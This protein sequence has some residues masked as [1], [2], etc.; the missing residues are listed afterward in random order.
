[1][2]NQLYDLTLLL[3]L[4]YLGFLSFCKLRIPSP[5]ILGSI[6]V[7][8]VLRAMGY[9]IPALPSYLFPLIQIFL[10]LFLGTKITRD[11]LKEIKLVYKPLIIIL[12]W[13][14]SIIFFLGFLLTSI[15]HLNI[16]TAIMSSTMGGL[17][18][19][20]VLAI[21]TDTEISYVIL[22]QSIRLILTVMIFPLLFNYW[23]NNKKSN[24]AF[25]L[26]N[27]Q[28]E[29]KSSSNCLSV[30]KSYFRFPFSAY[31]LSLDLGNKEFRDKL[32]NYFL[33]ILIAAI[34]GSVFIQVG[35]PAGGMIGAMVLVAIF[36]IAG[37][38]FKP[39]SPKL[40]I[41]VQVCVGIIVTENITPNTVKALVSL[42]TLWIVLLISLVTF[43]SSIFV[44]LLIYK[45]TNWDYPTCFLASAPGGFT[46][47]MSLSV[48][49]NIEPFKISILHLCR[50]LIIKMIIPFFY[51]FYR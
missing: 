26:E 34:G 44:S 5:A 9:P 35:F 49:Y 16:H 14:V 20:M 19:M 22:M 48:Q 46:A 8:G 18:E 15:T 23:M 10:G 29:T 25:N 13:T 11:I 3:L 47:I 24:V 43:G 51:M 12:V 6:V 30:S 27:K 17:P 33:L 32:S 45:T 36:S 41:L 42:D 4:G 40:L 39:L 37:V 38:K 28:L 31:Y 1:M 7:I 21:A 2:I 50:L